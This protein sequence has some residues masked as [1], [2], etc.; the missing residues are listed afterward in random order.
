MLRLLTTIAFTTAAVGS[1]AAQ[2]KVEITPTVGLYLPSANIVDQYGGGCGCQ[3][4]VNQEQAFLLGV[5]LTVWATRNLGLE[6]SLA[7]IGSGVHVVEAGVGS[8]DTTGTVDIISER[9]VWGFWHP[10]PTSTVYLAGG[11]AF[12]THS[13]PAYEGL[14]GTNNT[15]AGAGVGVR[16]GL[17]S[18]LTFKAE[19]E[20]YFYTAQFTAQGQQTE[21]RHQTD[22]LITI[23]LAIGL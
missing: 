7:T 6:T 22:K 23:G 14:S 10:N 4:S 18:S 19:G 1:L 17:G 13:S 20:E 9:V 2:A 16:L 12:I 5:R 21:A 8:G 3:V 15:G 11:L